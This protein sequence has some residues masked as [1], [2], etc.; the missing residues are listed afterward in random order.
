MDWLLQ[1]GI[2]EVFIPGVIK[3]LLLHRKVGDNLSRRSAHKTAF[4]NEKTRLQKQLCSALS[5]IPFTAQ[6]LNLETKQPSEI[7]KGVNFF[8]NN[9]EIK[10][11]FY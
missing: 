2:N 3:S 11:Y 1:L 6:S 7:K 10:K 5:A 4:Q 8:L 9:T